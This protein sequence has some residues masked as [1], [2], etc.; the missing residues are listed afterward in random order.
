MNYRSGGKAIQGANLI[1]KKFNHGMIL[2]CKNYEN[3][4]V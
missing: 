4:G 2:S 1:N 3:C